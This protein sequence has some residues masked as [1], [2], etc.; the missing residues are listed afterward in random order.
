GPSPI[1]SGKNR[2]V[3]RYYA[4]SQGESGYIWS[5]LDAIR[6]IRLTDL[7]QKHVVPTAQFAVDARA[8]KLP[9]V[10]C[11][12]MNGDASEHPPASVWVGENKTGPLRSSMPS[13]RGRTGA[14][15]SSSLPG[16]ISADS[17]ITF[18]R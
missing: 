1:G 11:V 17:T 16:T 12:V 6:H 4:P 3:G 8:S 9:A 5:A 14:P 10:S 15:Q 13:C 2:S 7:W 18:H